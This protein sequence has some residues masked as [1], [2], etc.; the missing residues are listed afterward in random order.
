MPEEGYILAINPWIYDFTAYDL[1]FKPYGLLSTAG[2]LKSYGYD[3][4]LLDCL[5]RKHFLLKNYT[6]KKPDSKPD[7]RG[8]FITEPI[9]KPKELKGVMRRYKRYGIPYKL[10]ED[11]LQKA[12]R[13]SAVLITSQITYWYPAIRDM[14]ELV[15]KIFP[16][17][18]LALGGIYPS[19]HH[20]RAKADISPDFICIN[21]DLFGLL[22]FLDKIFKKNRIYPTGCPNFEEWNNPDYSLIQ[23]KTAMPIITSVGCPYS[24]PFCI[25]SKRWGAFRYMDPQII[26]DRILKLHSEYGVNHFAF[27]DDALLH[28]KKDNL[29][30]IFRNV[31]NSSTKL[32]FHAPNG[33]FPRD[34]DKE[35]SILFKQ[36][37]VRTIRL[38]FE[39]SSP[40]LQKKMNKVTD[41]ELISALDNLESVGY[42]RAGIEIYLIAGLPE[43][44]T[45]DIIQ[46]MK[47]IN[48]QGARIHLA[49]YSPIPGT[50]SGDDTI[51]RFFLPDYD[52]VLT[53]KFAFTQWHPNIGWEGFESL[54]SIKRELNLTL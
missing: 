45:K 47:F 16:G 1:W 11:E 7:G 24:C 18:P 14:A 19:I 6:G 43:Q 36:T 2:F 29:F 10:V 34:M 26:S 23:D 17:T 9:S 42:D 30:K 53:N 22:R 54:R 12:P 35:T 49:Y 44:E 33:L 50:H 15:R 21:D 40:A 52:P 13:P 39:S 41:M 20:E 51:A 3:V 27:Y 5:D 28:R 48:D 4:K 31:I 32:N 8:K 46:S 38:S 25:T 37:G